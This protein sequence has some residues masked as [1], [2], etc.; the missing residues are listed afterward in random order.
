[1]KMDFKL[2]NNCKHFALLIDAKKTPYS[3]GKSVLAYDLNHKISVNKINNL[4]KLL[5]KN[6]QYFGYFSYDIKN[7]LE[8]LKSEKEFFLKKYP[9]IYFANFNK[10]K[11][12]KYTPQ[13]AE[14]SQEIEVNYIKSQFSK[15]EYISKI[16]Q[17]KSHIRNADVYQ[18]NLTN[19]FYGEFK[20]KPDYLNLF[21]KLISLNPV[22]FA[23]YIRIDD[24]HI[25]SASPEL[26][27]KIDGNKNIVTC[28]I[29]GTA[30]NNKGL[31]SEKEQAENLMITDLMRNDLAKVCVPNSVKVSGLFEK[32]KFKNYNHLYSTIKG[33]LDKN[34]D[35]IDVIKNIFPPGSMTGAPKISAMNIISELE[36]TK[37]GIYSGILGYFTNDKNAEFSVVIRTLICKGREFEFQVGGGI[38]YDSDP[39]KE[40]QEILTKADNI[41]KTLGISKIQIKILE[42][43]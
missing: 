6:K 14:R 13:K 19:K 20:E 2:L 8:K 43:D 32:E 30:K 42:G 11:T 28:P 9:Q 41:F 33:R 39:E 35:N 21:L 12:F 25:I 27:L 3:S 10:V 16:K 18:V 1:M 24:L 5:Q 29:K 23:G 40:Y 31:T 15:Q 26:F 38:T 7:Q 34:I 37:R 36:G 4:Q 22:P 17:I